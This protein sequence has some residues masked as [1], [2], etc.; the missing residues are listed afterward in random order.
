MLG[1]LHGPGN[2]ATI[3]ESVGGLK[4]FRDALELFHRN[5]RII[6]SNQLL[7]LEISHRNDR[8]ISSCKLLS[9]S[10]DSEA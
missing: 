1:L 3:R 8:I 6:S 7:S 10:G 2:V 9:A 4:C 5:D